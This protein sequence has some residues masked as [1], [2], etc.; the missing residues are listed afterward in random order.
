MDARFWRQHT[1][2]ALNAQ[3]GGTY[4]EVRHCGSLAP[5]SCDD[6]WAS[7]CRN[8]AIAGFEWGWR[9]M[10][11]TVAKNEPAADALGLAH[12]L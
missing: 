11:A 8:A 2:V 3:L 12:G 6:A 5:C 10:F 7:Q 9:A 4:T 1:A